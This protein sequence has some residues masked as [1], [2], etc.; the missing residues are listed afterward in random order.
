MKGGLIVIFLFLFPLVSSAILIQ[1][2]LDSVYNVGDLVYLNFSVSS[3]NEVSGFVDSY[4]VCDDDEM[5]IRKEYIFLNNQKKNFSLSFP[6]NE[7]GECKFTVEFLD[8]IVS[9]E[10]FISSDKIVI[11]YEMNNR[12][13]VPYEKLIINGTVKK[14]NGDKYTGILEFSGLTEKSIEVQNGVF[15][16]SY[17]I[18]STAVPKI[19][20][21]Y[22]KVK[23][24][25]SDG[26]IINSGE[27]SEEIE[28]KSKPTSIQIVALDHL[29]PPTNFSFH[30]KLLDQVG[31]VV[32]NNSVVVKLLD[33]DKNIL[34]QKQVTS[35]ENVTYEFVGTS[36]KGSS[37]INAYYGSISSSFPVYIE[38]YSAVDVI[39]VGNDLEIT[40]I[41]NVPYEGSVNFSL[42]NG[43]EK[44]DIYFN[45]SLE[46]GQ[47]YFYPLK[48]TG[49]YN[50]TVFDKEFN[51]AYLTGAA[52]GIPEDLDVFSYA[53]PIAFVLFLVWLYF[54]IK[55]KRGDSIKLYMED[56]KSSVI[57]KSMEV[58]TKPV[59]MSSNVLEEK[60]E[61]V[62]P[63]KK[64]FMLFLKSEN[65]I[66]GY[67][68][69]V[70]NY[71]FTLNHVSEDTGY[72][73]FYGDNDSSP[74]Y[75]IYNLGKNL[76]KFSEVKSERLTIVINKGN[77]E[78]KINLLKKFSL[79]NK[80]LADLFPGKFVVSDKIM[81]KL[82][83][84]LIPNERVVE[85][86]DR[87]IKVHLLD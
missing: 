67:S 27:E 8:N 78:K 80:K 69:T 66:E 26:K 20:K 68:Q 43:S 52:I 77:F 21:I 47:I 57:E 42:N 40:N 30:V 5:L 61:S 44:E 37:Y 28:I 34:L 38:D 1:D 4:L 39:L 18:A 76:K 74:D 35:L 15:N 9:S 65:S 86:M 70:K 49:I 29:K 83:L 82:Q 56:R 12:Y 2:N 31:N 23:E 62:T 85:V 79:F 6:L 55:K 13:F 32:E 19:Y 75:K 17:E 54:F 16:F 11:N 46:L 58:K 59:K 50:I 64:V 22:F 53:V 84:K 3:L 51:N 10:E 41:G 71:G 24:K 36:K 73:L 25:N 14:E 72:V 45:V 81:E 7:K 48:Y 87:K 33:V 60:N 63:V